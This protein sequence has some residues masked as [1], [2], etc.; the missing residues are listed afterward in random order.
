[1]EQSEQTGFDKWWTDEGSALRPLEGED[2]EEHAHRV[3]RIAWVNGAYTQWIKAAD[4]AELL[5]SG[6]ILLVVD[7]EKHHFNSVNLRMAIQDG[8]EERASV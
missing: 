5:N 4:D 8:I 6:T 2:A 7:G 3:S 1:M